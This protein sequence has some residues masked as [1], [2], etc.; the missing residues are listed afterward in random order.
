MS[1]MS[2]QI[3]TTY[4]I[5][6]KKM[7]S[8]HRGICF[9]NFLVVWVSLQ[10]KRNPSFENVHQFFLKLALEPNTSFRCFSIFKNQ[11][12]K[13]ELWAMHKPRKVK[14]NYCKHSCCK[15]SLNCIGI[16]KRAKFYEIFFWLTILIQKPD[17]VLLKCFIGADQSENGCEQSTKRNWC[18][19]H[20]GANFFVMGFNFR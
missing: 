18:M 20:R 6:L 2:F 1:K 14:N 13:I 10:F 16:V 15:H 4:M 12:R 3:S 17:N 11:F 5:T 19:L 8:I 7:N 9:W